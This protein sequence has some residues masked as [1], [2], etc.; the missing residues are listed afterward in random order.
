MRPQ[1]A[2]SCRQPSCEWVGYGEGMCKVTL[3]VMV[4]WLDPASPSVHILLR[5]ATQ[6]EEHEAPQMAPLVAWPKLRLIHFFFIFSSLFFFFFFGLY[7]E[8]VAQTAQ[9]QMGQLSSVSATAQMLTLKTQATQVECKSPGQSG[10][11]RHPQQSPRRSGMRLGT[12]ARQ[13]SRSRSRK[14]SG[15]RLSPQQPLSRVKGKA[16]HMPIPG[17]D[18][19]FSFPCSPDM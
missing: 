6:L 9:L 16:L 3:V 8:L 19:K 4:S 7:A 12:P 13:Q 2:L 10:T 5:I 11:A 18:E 14:R 1:A 17:M 15:R